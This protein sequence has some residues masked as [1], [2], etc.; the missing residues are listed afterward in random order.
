M[1]DLAVQKLQRKRHDPDLWYLVGEMENLL[2]TGSMA[3]TD[4]VAASIPWD[5]LRRQWRSTIT[6]TRV[7]PAA[8][9]QTGAV[10]DRC[11]AQA[12]A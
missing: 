4:M 9:G 12:L 3:V 2:V 6:I 1:C 10:R 7:T 8:T 11:I 5:E